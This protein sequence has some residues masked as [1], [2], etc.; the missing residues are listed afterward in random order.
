MIKRFQD[1]SHRH[2]RALQIWLILIAKAH[3]RQT[4]TYDELAKLQGYNKGGQFLSQQ[5]DP[6][7]IFCERNEL[8]PLTAIVVNK[9]S[10]LPGSGL[11]LENAN[12][13]REAVFRF[14]WFTIFPPAFE[15]LKAI[16]P[17]S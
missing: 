1:D 12:S 15:E 6:I 8:P 4:I 13:E 14:N 10:G 5:L 7:K 17:N 2:T 3:N 11:P 9:N 16:T